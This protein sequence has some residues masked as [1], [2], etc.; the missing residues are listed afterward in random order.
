MNS[1][2]SRFEPYRL[3][4]TLCVALT[5]ACEA[6]PASEAAVAVSSFAITDGSKIDWGECEGENLKKAGAVCGMLSVPLDHDKPHGTKIQLALS[7]VKHTVPDEEYQGIMLANP[8]GPGGSGLGMARLG[9]YIPKD[10]GLAY[11]WVG[12]DPRGVGSSV[13]TLSCIKDYLA[14]PRPSFVPVS[15]ELEDTWLKRSEEYAT[16]CGENGGEL[17]E[18][19][20]TIDVVRDIDSIRAALHAKKLNFYGFSYGTYIAQVYATTFPKRVRRF[21]LDSNVDPARVFYQSNLDQDIAFQRNIELFWSW[22][23]DH[24]DVFHLG[25]SQHAVQKAWYAE[26]AKLSKQPAGGVVGPDEWTDIFLSAGYSQGAWRDLATLWQSWLSDGDPAP[27][28]AQYESA[29][30]PDNDNLFAIYNAVQCT[31]ALWPQSWS[32]WRSD[33]WATFRE[34]PFETWGN[35]WFNAPC[36]FWPAKASEAVD[37]GSDDV[38]PIL[39]VGES[40][41]GATPFSG[42]L[43]VRK[44]FPSASLI[45]VVGGTTHGASL[46]GND[47]VDDLVADY[48]ATGALPERQDGDDPDVKCDALPLPEAEP[49]TPAYSLG[50]NDRSTLAQQ[51]RRELLP[52]H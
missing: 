5:A 25:R 51:L 49:E 21:V 42:S 48:L 30:T 18:H 28:V 43:E 6:A 31:D 46:N 27:V 2:T 35:A 36:L 15:A 34:A 20:R 7:M 9:Q 1:Q 4:V 23:A 19:I 24:D 11:D 45:E 39:L 16:A 50:S 32:Q 44:R 13:P 12:F 3:T 10:A 37:V 17:L 33:N 41:D 52:R 26:A 8:G 40:L 29:N 47:C 38:A 14:G 22:I